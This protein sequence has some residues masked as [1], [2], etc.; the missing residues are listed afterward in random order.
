ML[1]KAHSMLRAQALVV[2]S[3]QVA[4][5]ALRKDTAGKL[6]QWVETDHHKT[7]VLKFYKTIVCLARK[8]F[9]AGDKSKCPHNTCVK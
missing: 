2:W 6:G 8:V 5:W 4:N 1:V 3:Q 9:R 7:A